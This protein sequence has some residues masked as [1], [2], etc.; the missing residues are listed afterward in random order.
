VP[1]PNLS[2]ATA[3]PHLR[4][5]ICTPAAWCI[6][7]ASSSVR[8]SSPS[9]EINSGNLRAYEGSCVQ[10]LQA[11]GAVSEERAGTGAGARTSAQQLQES[12]QR[13]GTC[14]HTKGLSCQCLQAKGGSSQVRGAGA[15]A[16]TSAQQAGKGA[17]SAQSA[18][19]PAPVPC[20]PLRS[21][22]TAAAVL[23]RQSCT[24]LACLSDSRRALP[25]GA[26]VLR[27]AVLACCCAGLAQCGR[28]GR[29]HNTHRRSCL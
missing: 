18:Q 9:I 1:L 29:P 13:A 21:Q 14:A 12:E 20:A 5:M 15:G 8:W 22:G 16:R 3:Q 27:C 11:E 7:V 10:Y 26:A 24:R 17:V 4:V 28:W 19:L 23:V 6:A 2:P 25:Y